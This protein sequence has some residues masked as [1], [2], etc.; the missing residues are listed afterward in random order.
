VSQFKVETAIDEGLSGK[1]VR[2]MTVRVVFDRTG[3]QVDGKVTK[4]VPFVDPGSRT[5]P[6]EIAIRNT[7][8]L[9][10]GSYAKVLIPLGKK[11]TLLVPDKSIVERGQLTGVFVVDGQ[12][13]ITYRL[14]KT[15]KTYSGQTE[16]LSG[17][18]KGDKVI[19]SGIEK[20]VDGGAVKD[21]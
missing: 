8:S 7:R 20:A 9:K 10:S 17:L 1:I 19:I 12:G 21:K 13:I 5:F 15:G 3:E 16:V 2:D 6:V 11:D 14:I 4:V 18:T